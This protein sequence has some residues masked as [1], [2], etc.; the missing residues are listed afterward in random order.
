MT[1][2]ELKKALEGVS[3]DMLISV[4]SQG[5]M[6]VAY[7]AY[8]DPPSDFHHGVWDYKNKTRIKSETF[9]IGAA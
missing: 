9:W 6:V 1:V 4:E 3:D 7:G 8:V 5:D 2:G